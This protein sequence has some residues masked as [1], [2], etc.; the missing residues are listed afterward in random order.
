MDDTTFLLMA[1]GLI[2]LAECCWWVRRGSLV[3]TWRW[4]GRYRVDYPSAWAA[5][6][7]AGFVFLNP[8]PFAGEAYCC[9]AWPV[10]LS[11]FH[12]CS[13]T[14]LSTDPLGRPHQSAVCV[15][16]ADCQSMAVDGRDVW[17]NG[18]RFGSFSDEAAAQ[19][20][21]DVLQRLAIADP[22]VRDAEILRHLQQSMCVESIRGR[23]DTFRRLSLPLRI[24][25]GMLFIWLFAGLPTILRVPA[26]RPYLT[27]YLLLAVGLILVIAYRFSTAHQ[28]L[29]PTQ[30]STRRL[31]TLSL[32]LMPTAAMRAHY[33]LGRHLLHAAYPVSAA[34]ALGDLATFRALARRVILDIHCP[35]RPEWPLEDEN[36]SGTDLAFRAQLLGAL[37]DVVQGQGSDV[38]AITRPPLPADSS[39]KAYCPR[40]ETHYIITDGACEHCG[41]IPLR[42]FQPQA[43]RDLMLSAQ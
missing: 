15:P 35:M 2:Y 17:I 1:L 40:C 34:A 24:W 6:P 26:C 8:L 32:M 42:P 27:E 29:F 11:K 10:S 7:D 9:T 30:H 21:A 20:Y 33:T 18:A 38:A 12:A 3:L 4:R 37:E 14:A 39:C 5:S 36:L 43:A 19:H 25:G 31:A 16:W 22:A 13:Y 23:V 41:G 28:L